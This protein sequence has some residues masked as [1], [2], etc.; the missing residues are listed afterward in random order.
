MSWL[1]PATP[2]EKATPGWHTAR[3]LLWYKERA[4]WHHRQ[5]A[6]CGYFVGKLGKGEHAPPVIPEEG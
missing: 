5:M 1:P 4:K 6:A 2:E 3:S